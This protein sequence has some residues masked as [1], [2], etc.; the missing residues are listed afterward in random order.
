MQPVPMATHMLI[1]STAPEE[2][3]E[4]GRPFEGARKISYQIK[5]EI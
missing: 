4:P 5:F 3:E 1:L 2:R